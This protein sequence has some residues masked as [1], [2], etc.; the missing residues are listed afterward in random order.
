MN[1]NSPY[2][3]T[4]WIPKK[5]RGPLPTLYY[6]GHFMEMLDFV[7]RHYAHTLLEDHAR[8]IEDFH[9]LP[10][11]AQCLYV[12]LVNRKGRV[13]AVNKL[14]YPELGSIAPLLDLLYNDAWVGKPSAAHYCDVLAHLTKAEINDVLRPMFAGMSRT[15]KKDE[16]VL[17][18]RENCPPADFMA[19]L[20]SDRL[21]VQRRAD[22]IQY[23]MFLYFGRVQ[24]GLS[25]FTL[26]DL[27]L[28]RT[29]EAA[30]TFEPRF[31]DS[32]E[33]LENYYFASLMHKLKSA[34]PQE[35]EQL[36]KDA[37]TWPMPNFSTSANG[38]DELAYEL[39]RRLEQAGH[40]E[41][42]RQVHEIGE[43]A[44]CR[45]RVIRLLLAGNRRDEAE[46]RLLACM[47]NPQSGEEQ[48]MAE[49][50]YARKFEKKR[51]STRTD[52][53]RAADTIEIDEALSG[54]PE[55]AAIRYFEEHGVQAYR[56]ENLLWRTLFGLLF[57]KELFDDENAA[58][59]SPF[60]ASARR[61]G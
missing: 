10:E 43:S 3:Q 58:V 53:L 38:R 30:D 37:H 17:F 28:V 46:R 47:D 13:F 39:G 21:L 7:S 8:L 6:H 48:L 18:A 60:E 1:T 35:A 56:T 23:L 19:G 27:G 42:A 52:E 50:L 57:W 51:T 36:A 9:K 15:L 55:R 22:G 24:D 14:G 31:T 29:N 34:T 59:H 33:A 54:S 26:R 16:L 2:D 45:E 12:R 20:K 5:R 44:T 25:Q 40:A 41:L 32:A 61:I 4:H 49:D 11:N